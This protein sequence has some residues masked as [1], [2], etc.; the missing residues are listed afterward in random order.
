MYSLT[1]AII[2]SPVEKRRILSEQF[3]AIGH[4]ESHVIEKARVLFQS[5]GG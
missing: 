3:G 2:N 5:T 1:P 4:R